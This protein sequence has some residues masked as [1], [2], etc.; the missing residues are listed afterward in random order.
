MRPISHPESIRASINWY[1]MVGEQGRNYSELYVAGLYLTEAE[2]N[3]AAIASANEP[4]S[5]RVKITSGM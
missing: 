2:S 1:L 4:M 3:P 5:I